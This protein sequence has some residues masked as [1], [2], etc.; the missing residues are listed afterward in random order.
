VVIALLLTSSAGLAVTPLIIVAAV[1]SYVLAE[2]LETAF[3]LPAP[4]VPAAAGTESPKVGH[5][6][7]TPA[8]SVP[9]EETP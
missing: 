4:K 3:A 2:M 1:V 7:H 9:K 8:P 6:E 5:R